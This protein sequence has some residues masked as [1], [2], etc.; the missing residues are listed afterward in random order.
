MQR[1]QSNDNPRLKHLRLLA[2]DGKARQQKQ[3]SIIEGLHLLQ[4]YEEQAGVPLEIVLSDRGLA[5]KQIAAWLA[6]YPGSS[7]LIVLPDKLFAALST[8][9][10]PSGILARIALPSTQFMSAQ[11][12]ALQA[13][14][15]TSDCL[16]LDGVQDPGNVGAILRTAAA[17]GIKMVFM[18][19]QCASAWSPKVLRA[20][21][22][23]Q[24][25]LRVFE[26]VELEEFAR[27]FSGELIVTSLAQEAQSIYEARWRAPAAWVFGSEGQG[28]S[29]GLHEAAG[30]LLKIPLAQ[31]MPS[32]NVASAVAV[33]LFEAR[34]RA[35]A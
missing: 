26:A 14:E 7:P 3:E 29:P 13:K 27:C 5:N 33:C 1:I 30:K 9:Q 11:A 4:V 17:V 10:S 28:V 20:A 23:A 18:S 35:H 21:Q 34:R 12:M 16:L 6:A 15:T 19:E 8:T 25:L 24:F 22:G 31:G 2:R 32:L